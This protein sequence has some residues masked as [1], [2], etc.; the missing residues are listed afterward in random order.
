MVSKLYGM[1]FGSYSAKLEELKEKYKTKPNDSSKTQEY[2]SAYVFYDKGKKGI[3]GNAFREK[4]YADKFNN[5]KYANAVIFEGDLMFGTMSKEKENFDTFDYI[6]AK[7]EYAVDINGN[8]IVDDNEV[9]EGQLD[10]DA[11]KKAKNQ[12]NLKKYEVFLK[13]YIY[14]WLN[15]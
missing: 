7:D 14:E 5:P 12:G 8:G 10:T 2:E 1:T 15:K 4:I 6:Q 9:F 13:E 3:K 11:Y